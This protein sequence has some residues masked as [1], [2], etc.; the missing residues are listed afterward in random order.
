MTEFE[1]Y[2]MP[3]RDD[4]NIEYKLK[5]L[6]K[7]EKR[8][9]QIATQMRYRTNEGGGE[10][11]YVLGVYDDG[12]I[13]GITENEFSESVHTLNKAA[14]QNKYKISILSDKKLENK[15]KICPDDK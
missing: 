3:E 10:S 4:G 9:E 2:I 7:D 11:I 12:K 14:E 13:W 8:I 15:K 5:L 6:N 1:K